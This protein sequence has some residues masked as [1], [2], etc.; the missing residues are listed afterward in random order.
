MQLIDGRSGLSVWSDTYDRGIDELLAG[1]P[2]LREELGG[3]GREA[4]ADLFSVDTA[5]KT[6]L[7]FY[8]EVLG[9]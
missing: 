9:Y 5:V 1:N 6:S 4:V 3:R 2:T 8:H 7:A